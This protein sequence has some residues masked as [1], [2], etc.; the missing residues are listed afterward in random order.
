MK[1]HMHAKENYSFQETNKESDI[2]A[3]EHFSIT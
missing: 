3:S 1:N 2:A